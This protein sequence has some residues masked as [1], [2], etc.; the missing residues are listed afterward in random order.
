MKVCK[1]AI[2]DELTK[3]YPGGQKCLQQKRQVCIQNQEQ[4]CIFS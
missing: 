3:I 2:K 1:N 4:L